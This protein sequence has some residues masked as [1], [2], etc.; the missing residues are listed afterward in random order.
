MSFCNINYLQSRLYFSAKFFELMCTCDIHLVSIYVVSRCITVSPSQTHQHCSH[1]VRVNRPSC[2]EQTD[3]MPL[4]LSLCI[5][6]ASIITLKNCYAQS[7]IGQ[8]T[9]NL[10]TI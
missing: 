2:Q 7:I 1:T 8:Q 3:T 10:Y 9:G 4:K 6:D 5:P